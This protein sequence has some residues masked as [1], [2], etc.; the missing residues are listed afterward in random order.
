MR[1]VDPKE[2][3][4]DQMKCMVY[5]KSIILQRLNNEVATLNRM[6]VAKALH[7]QQAPEVEVADSGLLGLR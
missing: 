1:T 5:D 3:T 4:V 7:E 6:F 2:M